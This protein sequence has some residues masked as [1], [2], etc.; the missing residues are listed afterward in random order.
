MDQLKS[1]RRRRG[2]NYEEFRE[3]LAMR[4]TTYQDDIVPDEPYQTETTTVYGHRISAAEQLIRAV[5][6]LL[7]ALLALRFVVALF[8]ANPANPI[9]NVV[10][11]TTN[12]LVRPFQNWFGTMPS[13]GG[14]YI[15][16]PALATIVAVTLVGWVI[17]LLVRDYDN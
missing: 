14:G 16:L 12:W 10:F 13:G 4:G 9:V 2:P 5:T 17:S 6:G 7:S 1:T 3:T 11:N 15:D 8:S